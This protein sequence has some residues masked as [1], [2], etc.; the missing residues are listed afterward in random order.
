MMDP[1]TIA[2]PA[3]RNSP[4]PCGSGLRYKTCHGAPAQ[5]PSAPPASRRLSS[6][7]PPLREWP[8]MSE[9]E[10][11]TLGVIMERALAHQLAGRIED[12]EHDYRTVLGR[13]PDTHDALHML[14]VIELGRDNLKEAE[15][16]IHRAMALRSPHPAIVRNLKL[17]EEAKLVYRR[18][19]PELLCERALPIFADLVLGEPVGGRRA[20]TGLR[21]AG[22]SPGEVHLIGRVEAP[23][24][25][26]GWLLRRLAQLI[27][28]RVWAIDAAGAGHIADR[29]WRG[30]DAAIG[31][32]P[33]GGTQVIVGISAK[34]F[35]WLDHSGP[36]RV[37]V[38]CMGG[39]PS[40][41]LDQ[42]RR[43]ARDGARNV[44]LVFFSATEAGRFG[45]G[46]HVLVPPVEV[47]L[48]QLAPAMPEV[49]PEASGESRSPRHFA[50]AWS[51]SPVLPCLT[52]PPM[53]PRR[54]CAI[55]WTN[56]LSMTLADCGLSS[57]TRETCAS[58]P[59]RWAGWIRSCP[60]WM[61]WSC[62]PASGTTKTEC[63]N[64]SARGRWDC[65][66]FVRQ[67]PAG[68]NTS[69]TGQ[70]GCASIRSR[71]YSV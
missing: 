1:G 52:R 35:T 17:V 26:D 44:E 37:I 50:S 24:H 48:Q 29:P 60:D 57:A 51:A 66:Y 14:G 49:P 43:V 45:P 7:R 27:D 25:N 34:D 59:E 46:H 3:S 12:A 15:Q 13:A 42:L 21:A 33:R 39:A 18:E 63:R 8:D 40:A 19:S 11:D 38:F 30:I 16:L 32:Y 71:S 10:R 9:T 28:A 64:S 53:T 36:S 56:W 55:A 62:D 61:R 23:L 31:S 41:C 6:Y 2:P 69:R 54:R 70:M 58:S 20:G 65:R 67:R 47:P 5:D 68:R 22:V 4:C